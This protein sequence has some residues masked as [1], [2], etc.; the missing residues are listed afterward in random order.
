MTKHILWRSYEL[1]FFALES[2]DGIEDE[3]CR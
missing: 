3:I 2:E 1:E